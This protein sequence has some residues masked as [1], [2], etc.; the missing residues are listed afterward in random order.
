[1]AG[2]LARRV[3]RGRSAGRRVIIIRGDVTCVECGRTLGPSDY[4]TLVRRLGAVRQSVYL[5][6]CVKD[7]PALGSLEVV[8][9]GW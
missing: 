6:V 4:K 1:V 7:R 5:F 9:S 2:G 3:R 8:A